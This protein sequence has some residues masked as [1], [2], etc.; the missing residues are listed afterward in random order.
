MTRRDAEG[1]FFQFNTFHRSDSCFGTVG[2]VSLAVS[3]AQAV[4]ADK[5]ELAGAKTVKLAICTVVFEVPEISILAV[6]IAQM[7]LA[8]IS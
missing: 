4:I 1:P 7:S 6:K 8:L 5:K 3:S 2:A